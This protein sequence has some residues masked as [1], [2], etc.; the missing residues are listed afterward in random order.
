MIYTVA[1]RTGRSA[2]IN[3]ERLATDP[4]GA[5]VGELGLRAAV[6]APIVVGGATGA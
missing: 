3:G 4:F 6:G 1:L 2:R 5:V